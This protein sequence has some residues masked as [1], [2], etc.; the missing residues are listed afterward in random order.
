VSEQA[1]NTLADADGHDQRA[2]GV[3]RRTYYRLVGRCWRCGGVRASL[4]GGVKVSV[5][6]DCLRNAFS[7]ARVR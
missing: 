1:V 5:C 7:I 6:P 2:K 4:R 3:L